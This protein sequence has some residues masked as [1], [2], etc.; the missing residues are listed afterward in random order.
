[1]ILMFSILAVYKL[2]MLIVIFNDD[3]LKERL[4][5]YLLVIVIYPGCCEREK[6]N[7]L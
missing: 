6:G 1:M 2:N 7:W 4:I 3:D 5:I